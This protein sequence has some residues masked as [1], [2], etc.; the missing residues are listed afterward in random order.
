M[1]KRIKT[2]A[3][4]VFKGDRIY[5]FLSEVPTAVLKQ[6]VRIVQLTK[7]TCNLGGASS[8]VVKLLRRWRD[9]LVRRSIAHRKVSK[10]KR[11]RRAIK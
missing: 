10:K 2:T 7:K 1:A 11:S 4:L 3:T 9:E 5:S 8:F 6:N